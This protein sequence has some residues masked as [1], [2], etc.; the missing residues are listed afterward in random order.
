[1][2]F[3]PPVVVAGVVRHPV[4]YHLH[5]VVV[6]CLYEVAEIV[7]CAE[8]GVEG[9]VIGRGIVASKFPFASLFGNGVYG[10][11]PEYVHAKL[12]KAG[13]L[14]LNGG[15]GALWGHLTPVYL[16]YHGIAAPL[17]VCHFGWSGFSR[18][19]FLRWEGKRM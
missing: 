11:Y 17:G 9:L 1:M 12:F 6:G 7:H 16:I 15:N 19:V 2:V 18:H 13:N 5:A 10:H 4:Y 14:F 8:F 3:E